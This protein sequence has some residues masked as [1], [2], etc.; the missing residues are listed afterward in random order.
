MR[1]NY[2]FFPQVNGFGGHLLVKTNK[3]RWKTSSHCSSALALT[4][5]GILF[6]IVL[7]FSFFPLL[8]AF[9]LPQMSRE[10]EISGYLIVFSPPSRRLKRQSNSKKES[11]TE[12]RFS[13]FCWLLSRSLRLRWFCLSECKHRPDEWH[14]WKNEHMKP[15]TGLTWQLM[16]S[17]GDQSIKASFN[18]LESEASIYTS[19]DQRQFPCRRADWDD[20]DDLVKDRG[21]SEIARWIKA[22]MGFQC[23]VIQPPLPAALTSLLLSKIRPREQDMQF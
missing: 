11:W 2:S 8:L 7:F 16:M 17:Q 4:L 23:V 6:I 9:P 1:E 18:Q 13:R 20:C 19:W 12:H 5:P 21:D 22:Q 14:V 15:S 10:T 3:E